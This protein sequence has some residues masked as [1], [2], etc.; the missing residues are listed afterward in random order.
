MDNVIDSIRAAIV[1]D[2]TPE[3]TATGATACRA[4]LAALGGTPG[5]PLG[6]PVAVPHSAT[7]IANAVSA[8]R[9]VP[10]EQLLD[11]AIAKLRAALPAGVEVAPTKPINFHIIPAPKGLK[12]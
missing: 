4:I 6:A 1:S 12:P 2:A 9:G 8:L 5:Q 11:L 3:A 10:A 7:Q